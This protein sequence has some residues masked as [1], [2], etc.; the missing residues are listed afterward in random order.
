[1]VVAN[2]DIYTFW[3]E[4]NRDDDTQY[5]LAVSQ[6]FEKLQILEILDNISSL[7]ERKSSSQPTRKA[8]CMLHGTL[9]SLIWS[10]QGPLRASLTSEWRNLLALE[11]LSR[12]S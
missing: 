2:P 11:C 3:K 12:S 10:K 4:V 6:Y 5:A 9:C 8:I 7:D 1:M